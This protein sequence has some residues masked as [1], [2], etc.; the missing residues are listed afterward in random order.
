MGSALVAANDVSK[1][2]KGAAHFENYV[3]PTLTYV[4]ADVS[5]NGA[6]I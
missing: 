1:R 6:Q 5:L 2:M 3:A 4:I